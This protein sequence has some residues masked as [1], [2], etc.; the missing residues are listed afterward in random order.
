MKIVLESICKEFFSRGLRVEALKNISLEVEDGE[1]LTVLGPSGSGKSTLLFIIGGIEKASLGKVSFH[2]ERRSSGPMSAMVWQQYALFPWR[3]VKENIIFGNEV[4]GIP[5]HERNR[6]ADQFIELIQLKGFENHYPHELSGGMQQR[7]ALA[8]S[9]C[10][11][12]EILLM[13]EPLAALDAQTRT[14]MQLELLKIWSQFQ[15]TVV[16]VTHSIEEAVLLGDRVVILTSRPGQIKEIV[17]IDLE[18]PRTLD[19]MRSQA[20]HKISDLA[21]GAIQDELLKANS[22]K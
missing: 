13:D 14:L 5:K 12:P 3:T 7:V 10:N 11:D 1:F 15:K 20:F 2:G 4:R 18:R 21:W 17:K 16:Y 6:L 22:K 9:L 8:R 19:M